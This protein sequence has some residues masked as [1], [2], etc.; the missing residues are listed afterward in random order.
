MVDALAADRLHDYIDGRLSDRDRAAIAA[1]LGVRPGTAAE[2]EALRRQSEILRGINQGILDEPVPGRLLEALRRRPRSALFWPRG[3][4]LLRAAAAL[5]LLV[6]AGALAWQ[7][8]DGFVRRPSAA[9]KLFVDV[10]EA[11]AF[12]A[13]T[14]YPVDFA[15][16]RVA[17]FRSWIHRSFDRE[18]WPPDLRAL[19][20]SYRGGR[21]IPAAGTR[22]GL[23]QFRHPD[24]A[25]LS[26]FF[27]TSAAP[28]PPAGASRASEVIAIRFWSGDGLNLAVVGEPTDRNLE[29]AADAVF[30]F[31][32]SGAGTV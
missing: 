5:V 26:V 12:Y 28:P 2:V 6:A 8:G 14:S 18:V 11:H 7:I 16:E 19:G 27:W 22:L 25:D 21:L 29:A 13:Q 23:F 24:A 32:E 9:E 1:Y 10:V 31:Y 30:S 4:S 20:Y 3:S 17:E 15:P